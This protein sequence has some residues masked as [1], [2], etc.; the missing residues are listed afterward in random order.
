MRQLGPDR[1]TPPRPGKGSIYPT[2]E[3]QHIPTARGGT[4]KNN[5]PPSSSALKN[6]WRECTIL[7]HRLIRDRRPVAAALSGGTS[8]YNRIWDGDGVGGAL[9][10]GSVI[11]DLKEAKGQVLPKCSC[12]GEAAD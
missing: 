3:E 6:I 9:K 2:E 4:W 1:V 10:E 12:N 7:P 5:P 8:G 11:K